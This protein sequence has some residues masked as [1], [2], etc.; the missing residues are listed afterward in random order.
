MPTQRAVKVEPSD[1]PQYVKDFN[2]LVQQ[3]QKHGCT[4]TEAIRKA[5]EFLDY[6]RHHYEWVYVSRTN[7]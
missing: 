7:N 3:Y 4:A 5:E 2:K 1:H 6:Y